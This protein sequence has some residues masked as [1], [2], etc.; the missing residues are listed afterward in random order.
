VRAR[1]ADIGENAVVEYAIESTV[2]ILDGTQSDASVC[3]PFKL[4]KS[5]ILILLDFREDISQYVALWCSLHYCSLP[6]VCF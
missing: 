1:D 5:I 2:Y 3:N 6:Y 4:N